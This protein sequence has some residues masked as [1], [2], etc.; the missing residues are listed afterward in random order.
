MAALVA[1]GMTN[2]QAAS[3]LDLSPRTA[4]PDTFWWGRQLCVSGQT[5]FNHCGHPVSYTNYG[6]CYTP[7]WSGAQF[8]VNRAMATP[9]TAAGETTP[10]GATGN[11]PRPVTRAHPST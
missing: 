1:Q 8:C 5:T 11:S 2:R 10:A 3:A 9:W 7:S 4:D 6:W